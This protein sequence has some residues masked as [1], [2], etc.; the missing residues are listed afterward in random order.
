MPRVN[1]AEI[2]M[3]RELSR[4]TAEV[5]RLRQKPRRRKNPR[6]KEIRLAEDIVNSFELTVTLY[7]KAMKVLGDY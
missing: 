5:K 3:Q 6:S 4:R 1:E 7:S 2:K